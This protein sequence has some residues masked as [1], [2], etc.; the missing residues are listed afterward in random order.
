VF[1]DDISLKE[2][3]PKNVEL[4]LRGVIDS[5]APLLRYLPEVD[6]RTGEI[7]AAGA[8]IRWRHPT[9][10]LLLPDSFIGRAGS[11]NLAGEVGPGRRSAA[12]AAQTNGNTHTLWMLRTP[13]QTCSR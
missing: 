8:L 2:A 6:M 13:E 1:T 11:I 5:D 7:L 9:R 10:G 3:F 4:H 12:G